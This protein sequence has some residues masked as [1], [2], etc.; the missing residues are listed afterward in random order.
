[1][2][3][4]FPNLQELAASITA[5]LVPA[6]EANLPQNLQ[7]EI[8]VILRALLGVIQEKPLNKE[9]AD[10]IHINLQNIKLIKELYC[11]KPN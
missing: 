1:M 9:A 4:E 3:E 6:V 7:E 11:G 8:N 5:G 2:M 10:S